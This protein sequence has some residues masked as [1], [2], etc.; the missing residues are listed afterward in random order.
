VHA[1]AEAVEV[2]QRE[3]HADAPRD[4]DE[5]D[6]RVGRAADRGKR[7]D[8]VLEGRA[9]QD[10]RKD[11]VFF[12]H[13]HD[14]AARHAREHIAPR[15]HGGNRGVAR[16][17]DAERFHHRGHGR[18]GAHRHAVAVRAVHARFGLVEFLQRD[19]AGAQVFRHR[20]GIGARADIGA[21]VLARQ[22]RSAGD[23]D[24]RQ[25]HARG[26]HQRGGR[27]LVTAR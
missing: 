23:Q 21:A 12:H 4:R 1:P 22:H 25:V 24:R 8:R 20:P 16:H 7:A 10:L 14:P 17:A 15:V 3:L 9:H 5:V 19:L 2:L 13:L 26:A 6:H 18:G 27:G 11:E